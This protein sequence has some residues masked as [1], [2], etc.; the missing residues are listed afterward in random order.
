MVRLKDVARIELGAQT[1]AVKSRFNGQPSAL[2]AIYQLPGSNAIE[3]A[4]GAKE[5]MAQLE[6]SFPP[7]MAYTLTLDTTLAVT[8]G[9]KEIIHTLIEA[10]LLVIL[11]VFI[12]LQ[13]WRAT[14]I[15]APGRAG[16]PGRPRSRYFLSSAFPLTHFPCSAWSWPSVWWWTTPSSSWKP[17]NITSRKACRQKKRRSRPCQKFPGP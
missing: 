6:K 10:L 11:V 2:V 17:W 13:G 5:L 8:E 9:L 16:F 15:P 7:D 1:Y 12:F 14:L 3:A 4:N